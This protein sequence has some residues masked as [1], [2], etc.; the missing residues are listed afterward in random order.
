MRRGRILLFVI[1]IL[2]LFVVAGVV[3]FQLAGKSIMSSIGPKPTATPPP[4]KIIVIAQQ[5]EQGGLLDE[6]YLQAVPWPTSGV[7]GDMFKDSQ[8][9][10]LIGRQVKYTLKPGTPVLSTMLLTE[11]EQVQMSG[12]PWSLNIPTGLVAVSIPVSRL[13]SISYAPR[14]GDHVDLIVT[15]LFVDLDT[16]FQTMLPDMTGLVIASGPPDPESGAQL[17]LTV[18]ISPGI[19]GRTEFDPVLGQAIYLLPMEAQR[20]RMS[21]Q[22]LLQDAI[23]LQIGDFPLPGQETKKAT[24]EPTADPKAKKTEETK[25]TSKEP[26]VITLLVR[27]Q[28][29]VT[30]NYLVFSGSQ[31]TLALRHPNDA[32]RV[33]VVPVTLQ[34]LLETYQI[35]V[36]V[37]LPY[38]LHPRQ[39]NLVLPTPV[40]EDEKK[41]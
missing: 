10:E 41:K 23:V 6:E 2:V 39:D 35:P 12:S 18:D 20:P 19:G 40:V 3:V 21:S 36:P 14:A 34:Y 37:R 13:S 38:G 11:G 1:I 22:M 32:T 8:L 17:P 4:S 7:T 24:V 9:K 16:D 29:A 31:L 28:D 5:I 15:V 30:L 27:P 25:T 33:N 26:V